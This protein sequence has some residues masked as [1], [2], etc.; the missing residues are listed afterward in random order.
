MGEFSLKSQSYGGRYMY[1]DCTQEPVLGMNKSIIHW[2]LTV[3]GNDAVH[4]TT[5]P[6]TV[7]IDGQTV[8]FAPITFWNTYQF[9]AGTGSVSGQTE[10]VHEPDGTKTVECSIQTAIYTGVLQKNKATWDLRAIPKEST[11]GATDAFVGRTSMI[12]VDKKNAAYSHTIAYQ[13]GALQGYICSDGSTSEAPVMLESTNIAFLVPTDFYNEI[14]NQKSAQCRLICTTYAGDVQIGEEKSCSF[15]VS[16]QED[17][18]KPEL[19]GTVED[20]NEETIQLTG[21]RNRLIR[22]F[23]T[24]KCQINAAA[25]NGAGIK[26][27]KIA[28]ALAEE[29]TLIIPNVETGEFLFQAVDTRE[30]KSTHIVEK[31][32][33]PY[34][35]LTAVAVA[36]RT[37]PTSGRVQLTVEGNCFWG[38]F[39]AQENDIQ[40]SCFVGTKETVLE[41][42]KTE[43]GYLAQVYLEDLSY[44]SSHEIQVVIRDE[45]MEVVIAARVNPGM[46]VFDW[47]EK[48]FAF[49]VPVMLEDGAKAVSQKVLEQATDPLRYFPVDSIQVF[50]SHVSPAEQFGGTWERVVNP[51]TGEGVFLLGCTEEDDIGE[52]GGEATHTLTV[53]EMPGHYHDTYVQSIPGGSG[54]GYIALTYPAYGAKATVATMSEVGGNLA[55]NNIPPFVKVSI[56]RRVE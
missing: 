14:P 44:L 24:A 23:S 48:D 36:K 22:F 9:P 18:C 39:G 31:D 3:T 19:S 45:L 38:D 32:L 15:W 33:I 10:V 35:K 40:I 16:C 30:Y 11:I 28:D 49:H 54:G 46:P 42:T 52:F 56:W 47:G 7:I 8:Y 4:Y 51:E 20:C 34:Q 1:L 41:V 21:D 12:A 17:E 50:W 6:T 25:K 53:K 37:D 43:R 5:G 29:G 2:T 26:E 55:H 13:F 27:I